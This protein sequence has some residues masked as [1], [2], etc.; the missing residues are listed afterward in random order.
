MNWAKQHE[1]SG[2]RLVIDW[3][4][5]HANFRGEPALERSVA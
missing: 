5:L 1:A 2:G 4:S 3:E